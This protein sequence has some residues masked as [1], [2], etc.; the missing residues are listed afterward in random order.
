MRQATQ[1]PCGGA[2]TCPSPIAQ[3][4]S[5]PAIQVP[6]VLHLHFSSSPLHPT[7]A[8]CC[9]RRRPSSTSPRRHPATV[10]LPVYACIHR[11]VTVRPCRPLSH[12]STPRHADRRL[13]DCQAPRL[14][15][16]SHQICQHA[17]RP[18][19]M[20]ACLCL[21]HGVVKLTL[22]NDTNIGRILQRMC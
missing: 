3:G 15:C 18:C 13:R 17:A 7:L 22:R 14:I 9:C 21:A 5:R 16:A 10:P 12:V 2:T 20:P 4:S 8:S 1:G 6:G 19:P 11:P